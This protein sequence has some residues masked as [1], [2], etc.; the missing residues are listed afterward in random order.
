MAQGGSAGGLGTT[1]TKSAQG[2]EDLHRWSQRDTVRGA[3]ENSIPEFLS[4]RVFVNP[5]TPSGIGG[6]LGL[7]QGYEK[8]G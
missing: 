7:W 4:S 8:I 6:H 3:R 2:R 1:P 5:L